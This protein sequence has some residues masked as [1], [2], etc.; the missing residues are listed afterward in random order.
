MYSYFVVSNLAYYAYYRH[1]W[2]RMKKYSVSNTSDL[3]LDGAYCSLL[4]TVVYIKI[5]VPVNGDLIFS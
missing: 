5:G 4:F 1:K 3:W 2:G